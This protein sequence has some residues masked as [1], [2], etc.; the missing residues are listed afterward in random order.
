MLFC[1]IINVKLM[2]SFFQNAEHFFWQIDVLV[3]H[4]A[5]IKQV[6]RLHECRVEV[7]DVNLLEL[8]LSA[9]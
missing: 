1:Q 2:Y 4:V 3:L 8:E 6:D 9:I 5:S 7:P